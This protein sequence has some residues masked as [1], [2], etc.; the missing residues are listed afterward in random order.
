[1][2]A[3]ALVAYFRRAVDE[4]WGYVWGL[5]GTLYTKELAEKYKAAGRSTSK[6]RN[7][8]TYWTEDCKRWF[9]RMCADC[10]GGIVGAM[11]TVD[12]GYKDRTANTFYSQCVETGKI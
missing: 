7:P 8:E 12:P 2:R 3:E 9:G 10:S 6:S 5:N 11:R 4:G 1:M